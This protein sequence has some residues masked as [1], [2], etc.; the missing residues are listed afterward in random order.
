MLFIILHIKKKN[1]KIVGYRLTLLTIALII[2]MIDNI[3]NNNFENSTY[4][5]NQ[6]V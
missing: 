4:T 3:N 1:H 5:Y 6:S 2:M